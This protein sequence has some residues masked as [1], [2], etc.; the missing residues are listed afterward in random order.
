MKGDTAKDVFQKSGW[1]DST[2][3]NHNLVYIYSAGQL[4]PGW[5]GD[6]SAT[7]TVQGVGAD[8][9]LT[10]YNGTTTA[11]YA[12]ASVLY[13]V[14]QADDRAIQGLAGGTT[15]AGMFGYPKTS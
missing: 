12:L 7:G 1:S 3:G 8:G 9:K 11:T 6:I 13:A 4:Y 5:F 2:K 15:V 14:A 10:T